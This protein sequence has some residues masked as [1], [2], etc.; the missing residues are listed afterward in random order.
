MNRSTW[1]VVAVFAIATIGFIVWMKTSDHGEHLVSVAVPALSGVA[2][3]GEALFNGNCMACHGA[4]AA[5]SG[6]GPP[7]IHKIYEP[8]HHGDAAFLSAVRIGVR[9]H[10]WN[11]G[12]MP[13][14][15]HV[16]DSDAQKI[17]VYIRTLQ[18]S[19]G[20]N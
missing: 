5:G 12:N 1:G 2:R 14:Q 7:L 15:V 3:A 9:A 8:G 18:R 11:F 10:H 6:N 19:N 4:N 13:A 17:I 16:T 20:I